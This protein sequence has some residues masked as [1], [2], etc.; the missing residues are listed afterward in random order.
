MPS[1]LMVPLNMMVILVFARRTSM[2]HTDNRVFPPY[3][4]VDFAQVQA[5]CTGLTDLLRCN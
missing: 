3:S 1:L 2:L 5:F 4:G